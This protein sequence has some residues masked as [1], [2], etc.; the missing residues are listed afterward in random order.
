M[1]RVNKRSNLQHQV[2]SRLAFECY[3]CG[4]AFTAGAL[5]CESCWKDII[6]DGGAFGL[7]D[8]DKGH[9][10]YAYTLSAY[11]FP[12]DKL[13]FALKYQGRVILARE[14]GR[15]LAEKILADGIEKP[16]YLL[17]VPLHSLRL[18]CRGFNQAKEIASTVS[19]NLSIPLLA[20]STKRIKNTRPQFALSAGERSKNIKGAFR[21]KKTPLSGSV[22]IIDD[23]FTT[24][25]TA[26]ELAGRLKE[27]GANKVSLWACA[28]SD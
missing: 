21:V 14:L 13:L 15:K 10:D 22:A 7:S 25:T 17:P 28:R 23:I 16:D 18:L 12:L 19:A 9:L 26:N 1:K 20:M 4:E 2:L 24:G 8:H 11:C 5:L 6:I 3:L 27:A